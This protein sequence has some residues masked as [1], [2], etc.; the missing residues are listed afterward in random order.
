MLIAGL[1][2]AA[3]PFCA[4]LAG[5]PSSSRTAAPGIAIGVALTAAAAAVLPASAAAAAGGAESDG[6]AAARLARRDFSLSWPETIC[7]PRSCSAC[8][9]YRPVYPP[10]YEVNE[11]A[12]AFLVVVFFVSSQYSFEKKLAL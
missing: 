2:S 4:F 6:V 9:L 12:V 11:L 8:L 1:L 3:V 10:F 7:V 5:K